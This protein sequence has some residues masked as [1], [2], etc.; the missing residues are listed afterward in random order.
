MSRAFSFCQTPSITALVIRCLDTSSAARALIDTLAIFGLCLSSRAC[1]RRPDSHL[2]LLGLPGLASLGVIPPGLLS[3][4]A[5]RA[6]MRVPDALRRPHVRS[7]HHQGQYD[8]W[9]SHYDLLPLSR[10]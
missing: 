9:N 5:H 7:T 3:I 8:H 1:L 4:A 10:N 2:V 6:T